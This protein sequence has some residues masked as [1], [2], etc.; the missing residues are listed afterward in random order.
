MELCIV[1]FS[2]IKIDLLWMVVSADSF[3]CYSSEHVMIYSSEHANMVGVWAYNLQL[4]CVK[5]L[6]FILEMIYVGY[7]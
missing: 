1:S 7:C 2:F 6:V 4:S 5:W 3:E